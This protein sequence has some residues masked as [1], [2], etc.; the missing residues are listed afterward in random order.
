[1]NGKEKLI[2]RRA[3]P[4]DAG[5]LAILHRDAFPDFFLSSLGTAFLKQFYL[6]FAN[7]SS[8]ISTVAQLPDGTIIGSIVGTTEPDGFFSRLLRSRLVP[9]ALISA[10]ESIRRPRIIPR[11]LRAVRFRGEAGEKVDGA[12]L[13]SICVR[14]DQQ[15]RGTGRL[16]MEEWESDAAA[17]GA[18]LAYL[19]TDADHNESVNSFYRRQGWELKSGYTTPEG[20]PMNLYTKNISASEETQA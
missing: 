5:Q 16:M 19:T 1:M 7:D 9:F 6:G 20:R 12:L 17:D 8:A 14:S 4:A 10:R 2:L 3:T 13:S 15:G 11:L 18:T